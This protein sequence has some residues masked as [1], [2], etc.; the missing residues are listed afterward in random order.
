MLLAVFQTNGFW[1][2]FKATFW[3]FKRHFQ[4]MFSI[5]LLF[6]SICL[7]GMENNKKFYAIDSQ[8]LSTLQHMMA[9]HCF[10]KQQSYFKN[11]AWIFC[12]SV[13]FIA[14]LSFVTLKVVDGTRLRR[15]CRSG[16]ERVAGPKWLEQWH[17]SVKASIQ[18][19][20]G[21]DV[22]TTKIEWLSI[23]PQYPWH[24][25][26]ESVMGNGNSTAPQRLASVCWCQC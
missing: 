11:K 20:Q 8:S 13:A 24:T 16:H 25:A 15:G 22:V 18:I 23:A 6:S 3:Y 21:I 9:V 1:L 19:S 26:V 7:K 17:G 2:I 5:F 10:S 12:L 14:C 4:K